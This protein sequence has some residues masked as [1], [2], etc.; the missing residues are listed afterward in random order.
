MVADRFEVPQEDYERL[1][2]A[3]TAGDPNEVERSAA[4]VERATRLQAKTIKEKYVLTPYSV[5]FAIIFLTTEGLFA[6]SARRPGLCAGVQATYAPPR[7]RRCL[8][9]GGWVSAR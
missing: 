8:P 9:V 5:D 1:L 6:E 7:C 3:Q 2:N 4:A